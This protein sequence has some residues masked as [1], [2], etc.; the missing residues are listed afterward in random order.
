MHRPPSSRITATGKSETL[1]SA[2]LEH[3]SGSNGSRAAK[4]RLWSPIL[5]ILLFSPWLLKSHASPRPAS[6]LPLR[7]PLPSRILLLK[8]LL[9]NLNRNLRPHIPPSVIHSDSLFAVQIQPAPRHLSSRHPLTS[10]TLP[11]T[12]TRHHQL[13]LPTT[14]LGRTPPL[15]SHLLLLAPLPLSPPAILSRDASLQ[16]AS[17]GALRLSSLPTRPT[18]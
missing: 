2:Q 13:P 18:S 11:L 5:L 6:I 1:D 12:Q 16:V 8:S 3:V 7:L 15:R 10:P 4:I 17:A 14:Q 9:A